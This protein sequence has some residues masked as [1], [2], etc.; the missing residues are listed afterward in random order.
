VLGE[1]VATS[2]GQGSPANTFPV[3]TPE[4]LTC[5]AAGNLFVTSRT[6]VRLLPAAIE[7]GEGVGVVDGSGAVQ[8]IY[9]DP[10]RDTYPASVTSCLT[11]IVAVDAETVYAADSC[12][13]VLVELWRQPR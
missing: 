5:D 8:T 2:S 11:G 3:D 13:G 10:P 1:G 7:P 12:T 6:T 4:G 9:G